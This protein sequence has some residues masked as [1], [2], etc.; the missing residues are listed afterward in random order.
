MGLVHT[1]A[2]DEQVKTRGVAKESF[3][4]IFE[5]YEAAL[6]GIE[7]YSHIFVIVYFNKLRK[8]QIGPMKVKPRGMLKY[9]FQLEEL[10]LLGV[11]SLDSP[12]RPNPIGLTLA[13]LIKREGRNL[14]VSAL[15]FFEGTPVLD[16]KPMQ[17][18]YAAENY[19]LPEWYIKFHKR[20]GNV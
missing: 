1:E 6:E 19:T 10:P 9:G 7:Q 15:D 14:F 3:V 2:S 18:Q 11:F 16:I 8:E 17:P 20:S 12:T 5:E 13:R 4:E